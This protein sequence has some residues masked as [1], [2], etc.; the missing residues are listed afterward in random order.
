MIPSARVIVRCLKNHPNI[1]NNM[2]APVRTSRS[3]LPIPPNGRGRIV[4]L[5]PS[6]RNMLKMLLP[7]TLP[8]AMLGLPF[9]AAVI[10]VA[11]SGSDVP[12]AT[13]VKP[14]MAS[15][16]PSPD[17]IPDAPL[18][19]RS[20]PIISPASPIRESSGSRSPRSTPVFS[21]PSPDSPVLLKTSG[22]GRLLMSISVRP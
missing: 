8:R 12:A 4:A 10:D 11:S 13:I 6:T 21:M 1:Q 5:H 7:I 20:P 16:T 2:Q 14:I 17:A 18:T 3:R 9:T 19:N 15:L 22:R